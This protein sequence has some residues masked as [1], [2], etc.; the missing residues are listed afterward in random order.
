MSMTD[1]ELAEWAK[2]GLELDAE[3]HP[4]HGFVWGEDILNLWR[5]VG[6]MAQRH[7]DGL[8]EPETPEVPI[9]L[10]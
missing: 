3:S 4:A 8:P 6:E 9:D 10:V 5:V 1:E 7:L 2:Y